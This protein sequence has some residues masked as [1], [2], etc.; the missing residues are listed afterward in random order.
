MTELLILVVAVAVAL[1]AVAVVAVARRP[2]G[3]LPPGAIEAVIAVANERV[4]AH[5]DAGNREL[6]DVRA[7]LEKVQGLVH[8]L[9]RDREA[10]FGDLTGQLRTAGEQTA[11]LAA[12]TQRLGEALVGSK[13]RGQWG[14]RMADDVL[15]AAGFIEHVNYRKQ[16]AIVGGGVPDFTFL[17]PGAQVCHMDVKFPLDNYLR[18]LDAESQLDRQRHLRQ[19]QHD[20]RER[21]KELAERRYDGHDDSIDL[22]LLFIPNEQVYCFIQE[23]DPTLLDDA[24]ARKIVLCSPTT[25]FAVLAV[26]R[27]ASDSFRLE[28][29]SKEVVALLGGFAKQWDAFTDQMDRVGRRVDGLQKDYE[30][31]V[32]TRR[33]QLDRQIDRIEDLRRRENLPALEVPSTVPSTDRLELDA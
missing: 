4:G 17:L 10:K 11:V 16:R 22:V 28:Q 5:T 24:L 8:D 33:R 20:V 19:F 15:Q 21:V 3:G 25:L 23:H 32:G 14:E 30:L 7:T 26:I 18:H 12:T 9:E 29:R 6:A 13:S 31:L 2:S 27:Q 1:A